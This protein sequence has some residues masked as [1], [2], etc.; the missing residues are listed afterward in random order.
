MSN[1]KYRTLIPDK[2]DLPKDV[3]K[4]LSEEELSKLKFKE[5]LITVPTITITDP[6]A[7]RRLATSLDDARFTADPVARE[8]RLAIEKI[9]SHKKWW[10]FWRK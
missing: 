1:P 5:N 7:A 9:K 4:D 8:N 2:N 6:E 10:E 3:S